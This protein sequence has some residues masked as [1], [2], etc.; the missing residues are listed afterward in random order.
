MVAFLS[1]CAITSGGHW[2]C[3]NR[4]NKII[5]KLKQMKEIRMVIQKS[6][7]RQWDGYHI[8]LINKWSN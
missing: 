5:D 6:H 4:D 7:L 2:I 3:N 1:V 8:H